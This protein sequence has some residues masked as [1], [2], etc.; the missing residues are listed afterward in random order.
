MLNLINLL[1]PPTG[2]NFGI[3]DIPSKG[4]LS[5]PFIPLFGGGGRDGALG[6]VLALLFASGIRPATSGPLLS[7]VVVFFS[8]FPCWMLCNNADRASPPPD[9]LPFG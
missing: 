9:D 4:P 6:F 2:F 7:T 3:P 1:L 5:A 8:F